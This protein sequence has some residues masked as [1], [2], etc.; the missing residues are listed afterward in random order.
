MGELLTSINGSA[1]PVGG[2][3]RILPA[4]YRTPTVTL[5]IDESG[6][7]V[8]GP[9][10]F[11]TRQ[12]RRNLWNGVKGQYFSPNNK[13]Q[14]TDFPPV[15]SST[16]Q[17]EDDNERIWRDITLPF[18]KSAS[19]AQRIAKIL[20]LRNRRQI[21][22]TL[23]CNLSAY[24]VATGDT[25]MVNSTRYGW[26]SKVFE[27]M[28][29]S[30]E[31]SESQLGVNLT[32]REIDSAVYDWSTSEEEDEFAT[33]ETT[34]PDPFT[35]GMPGTPSFEEE[36]YETSGSAGV[37]SRLI[38]T[39]SAPADQFVE[40]GGHYQL[41]YKASAD[42]IWTI[43][44]N[45]R[46]NE[47]TIN[48]AQPGE[49]DFRVKS[50]SVIGVES[51]YTIT[52]YVISG[53]MALPTGVNSF[54]VRPSNGYAHFTWALHD[55]LD[56]RIGGV[57]EIRHVTSGG[58]L[59]SDSAL[60]DRYDGGQ[61]TGVGPLVQGYYLARARDSSDNYS[62]ATATFIADEALITGYTTVASVVEATTFPG[63]KVNLTVTANV[64]QISDT[65]SHNAVYYFPN[66]TTGSPGYYID[67][68]SVAVRRYEA[69]LALTRFD[70]GDLI[71]SRG[72]VDT[73]AS[74]DGGIVDVGE[75]RLYAQ[76][77]SNHPG[78]AAGWRT[79][80]I[81]FTV[82][83]FNA[84]AARFK[85]EFETESDTWNVGVTDLNVHIKR[86]T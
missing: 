3:W 50:I 45:L 9:V 28:N 70:A 30:L 68:G 24:Q 69:D 5:E 75:A 33:E 77:T 76:L 71:D 1:V 59:W 60:I 13:W 23:A 14:A 29:T 16:Y 22:V 57:I 35:V 38:I 4:V 54:A 17:T 37:K 40:H 2:K 83:D 66:S 86:P 62:S 53:L 48:D 31:V 8:R 51:A 46:A 25:V 67:C 11:A 6:S 72:L 42:S 81:P 56:V 85:L 18:T 12:S 74:V 49:F 44:P 43:A 15:A 26:D 36:L 55:D 79:E 41:E 47:Y 58:G 21:E 64:L 82:A 10:Q 73:W 61:V 80:W 39:W 19:M 7:S 63:S 84:R 32:L 78:S 34:L 20:L 52:S 27:V 65:T